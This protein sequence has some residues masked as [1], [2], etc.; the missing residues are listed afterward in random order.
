VA[1]QYTWGFLYK[2]LI[3]K[4]P[5]TFITDFF[6]HFPLETGSVIVATIG[7][8]LAEIGTLLL[9]HLTCGG[10]LIPAIGSI[11]ASLFQLFAAGAPLKWISHIFWLKPMKLVFGNL[12]SKFPLILK[13]EYQWFN[14]NERPLD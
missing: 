3:A 11:A 1:Y 9:I 10:R 12:K 4:S 14:G 6:L 5:F 8:S 2:E 7:F 13:I